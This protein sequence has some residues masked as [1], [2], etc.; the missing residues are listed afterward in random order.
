MMDTFIK[1]VTAKSGQVA[2]WPYI[3]K[4]GNW[5]VAAHVIRFATEVH[6]R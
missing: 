6:K 1:N 2:L 5:P 3:T 4:F